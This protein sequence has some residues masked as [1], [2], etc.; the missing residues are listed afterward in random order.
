MG[1][2]K[3]DVNIIQADSLYEGYNSLRNYT[4]NVKYF[5]GTTSP[6]FQRECL[7]RM[8]CVAVI[9]YDKAKDKIVLLE[10]FR[11]G[12]LQDE[13]SPW[14]YEIVAGVNDKKGEAM[15]DVAVRELM[16]ESGLSPLEMSFIMEYWVSPGASDEK[17]Y[18]Y[19]ANVDSTK[20]ELYAG[21]HEEHEDIKVH[22]FTFDEALDLLKS[23][24]IANGLTIMSLQWLQLNRNNLK[25]K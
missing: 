24:K 13:S 8:P 6:D 3:N 20:V 9:P 10:Q 17:V 22:V 15:L 14:L 4:L 12:A 11:V 5:N 16:E 19:Y 18:L 1:F 21:L 7:H 2:K 23:G 25:K